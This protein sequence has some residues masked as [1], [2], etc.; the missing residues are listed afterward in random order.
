MLNLA[1]QKKDTDKQ[2]SAIHFLLAVCELA[3]NKLKE[4]LVKNN[5]QEDSITELLKEK[6]PSRITNSFKS[7]NKEEKSSYYESQ[8]TS[9]KRKFYSRLLYRFSEKKLSKAKWIL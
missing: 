1:I 6:P 9:K 4:L 7:R 5:I 3:E 8:K 2:I